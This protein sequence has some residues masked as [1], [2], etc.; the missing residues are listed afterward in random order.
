MH[1]MNLKKIAYY[2]H[3]ISLAIIIAMSIVPSHYMGNN[4]IRLLTQPCENQIFLK[5]LIN[6]KTKPNFEFSGS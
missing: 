2:R 4:R 5:F 3:L 1:R 6:I